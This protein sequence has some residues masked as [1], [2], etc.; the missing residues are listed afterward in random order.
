MKSDR[1]GAIAILIA[2]ACFLLFSVFL[3]VCIALGGRVYG[4]LLLLGPVF[5]VSCYGLIRNVPRALRY[6]KRPLIQIQVSQ[7]TAGWVG[8]V[9]VAMARS[10]CAEP[11]SEAQ[12]EIWTE[13]SRRKVRNA[14]KKETDSLGKMLT[15]MGWR[16]PVHLVCRKEGYQPVSGVVK[17]PI[18]RDG[19]LLILLRPSNTEDCLGVKKETGEPQE[20]VGE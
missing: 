15:D 2:S 18:P 3:F 19:V 10:L 8:V 14:G 6:L 17:P 5:L 9:Q 11:L 12:V 7:G 20:Q 16:I 1:A 4:S 13:R